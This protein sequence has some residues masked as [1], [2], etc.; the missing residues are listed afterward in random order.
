MALLLYSVELNKIFT[1]RIL[2]KSLDGSVIPTPE[3]PFVVNAV[4][5]NFAGYLYAWDFVKENWDK[6]TQK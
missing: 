1:F 4:C 3:F 2:Q 5:K 6:I